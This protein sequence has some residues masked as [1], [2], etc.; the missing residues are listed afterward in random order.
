MPAPVKTILE[1]MGASFDDDGAGVLDAAKLELQSLFGTPLAGEARVSMFSDEAFGFTAPDELAAAGPLWVAGVDSPR[2]LRAACRDA[3]SRVVKRV[4]KDQA[5]LQD[6]GADAFVQ[7]PFVEARAQFTFGENVAVVALDSNHTLFL[8]S[9]NR[10]P[11][12]AGREVLLKDADKAPR[13]ELYSVTHAAAQALLQEGV[14]V[15]ELP[16]VD[17]LDLDDLLMSEEGI[18]ADE[19]DEGMDLPDDDDD[20]GEQEELDLDDDLDAIEDDVDDDLDDDFDDDVELDL[21]DEDDEAEGGETA[22]RSDP[23]SLPPDPAAMAAVPDLDDDEFEDEPTRMQADIAI[24]VDEPQ[25]SADVAHSFASGEDTPPVPKTEPAGIDRLAAI[26]GEGISSGKTGAFAL[27]AEAFAMLRGEDASDTDV[28]ADDDDD[29]IRALLA[30]A[31]ELEAKAK[32]LRAAAA[33]LRRERRKGD[34]GATDED[35]KPKRTLA[36]K[37]KKQREARGDDEVHTPKTT[38]QVEALPSNIEISGFGGDLSMGDVSVDA[39]GATIMADM[40]LPMVDEPNDDFAHDSGV[41]TETR[42]RT[43]VGLVVKDARARTRL[44][45]QLKEH[46]NDL[47]AIDGPAA[48]DGHARL[49]ECIALVF[50][51]P[52]RNAE[53]KNAL[54]A[55]ADLDERPQTLV[56]SPEAAW[57]KHRAVDKRIDLA[58]RAPEVASSVVDALKDMGVID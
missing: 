1:R 33:D 5:L 13:D 56:V 8:R 11:I 21:D 31:E 36:A 15:G 54:K 22:V 35:A 43:S 16:P 47:I 49:D 39:G 45:K 12:P 4:Q 7:A 24:P 28:G 46:V 10:H 55:L 40:Q 38:V 27:D 58:R 44:K 19:L 51:R 50:V 9:L 57:Q 20:D 25:V 37:L 18:A 26:V 6:A 52:A 34:G 42:A 30:E 29:E 41:F 14:G 2:Q 3:H 32:Q 53:T 23:A 17:D 48:L